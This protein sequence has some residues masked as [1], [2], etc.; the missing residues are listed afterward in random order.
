MTHPPSATGATGVTGVTVATI[1]DDEAGLRLD[2]WFR[3]HFP[4]ITHARLQK[5]LRTGQ[6]RLEGRRAKA[7]TRL[8]AGQS[9][10]VP[11][12]GDDGAAPPR[13]APV[14][15]ATDAEAL[16]AAVLHRDDHVIAINKPPG[17]AVQGGTGTRRHLDAMLDALRVD[18]GERPRL[19]HRLDKDTSGVLLLAAGA[20]AAA[21]LTRAFRAKAARKVYWAAVAGVPRPARG[22]VDQ[23]LAKNPGP[24]RQRVAPDGATGKTAVTL[25]RVIER[26]GGKAAWLAL[27]P[28][29]G[30]THQLRAHC[31]VLGT[32]VL[33]DGK[34]GGRGAFIEG[35][36]VARRMHL[37]ARAIRLPH[38]EEGV[39]EVVA[40]LPA[41]MLATW[42]AL[43]FDEENAPDP[44]AG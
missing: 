7:G 14:V 22:R 32:P 15:S 26:A 1:A 2:R 27:E 41:H 3:R 38:P 5:L 20:A 16:S 40:P 33:G 37:H 44:F 6:V 10:R 24:G 30:R 18:G 17:L 39:L 43:G 13:E 11:P 35:D 29:T 25:Y 23:P 8:A 34:Y 31:M 12:L 4:Q 36:A 19:V 9:V 42:R 28:V 21:A